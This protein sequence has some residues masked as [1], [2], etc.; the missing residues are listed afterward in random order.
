[1][2]PLMIL[3]TPNH[4]SS[5]TSLSRA[6]LASQAWSLQRKGDPERGKLYLE[7]LLH[8]SQ[9]DVQGR[10]LLSSTLV[11]LGDLEGAVRIARHAHSL[12][13]QPAQST[14]SL[15]TALGRLARLPHLTDSVK[16]E[17]RYEYRSLGEIVS[18]THDWHVPYQ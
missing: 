7:T 8:S 6:D 15:A 4:L 2:M 9:N 11:D 5:M 18:L 14:V 12:N 13:L 10:I 17:H 1:M 16:K 3:S